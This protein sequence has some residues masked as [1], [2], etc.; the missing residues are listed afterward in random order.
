MSLIKCLALPAT[1]AAEGNQNK[2]T[3]KEEKKNEKMQKLTAQ[4]TPCH[5]TSSIRGSRALMAQGDERMIN[6]YITIDT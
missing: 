1:G 3:K 4:P 6:Y 2:D 5:P